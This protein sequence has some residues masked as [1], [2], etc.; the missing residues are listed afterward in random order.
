MNADQAPTAT[1]VN[2]GDLDDEVPS[3]RAIAYALHFDSL[4]LPEGFSI[5]MQDF[6]D[7]LK[8]GARSGEVIV[9]GNG[10]P[11][12]VDEWDDDEGH[13]EHTQDTR[14]GFRIRIDQ[15]GLD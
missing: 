6:G 12:V 7:C 3:L 1:T 10:P 13:H 5:E 4:E 9:S 11:R 2:T 8:P 15:I 14:W